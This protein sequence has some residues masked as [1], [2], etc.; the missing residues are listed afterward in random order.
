MFLCNNFWL[1]A[2]C[3]AGSGNTSTSL[4]NHSSQC[5]QAN[6]LP[7]CSMEPMHHQFFYV[8]TIIPLS[9]PPLSHDE[10]QGFVHRPCLHIAKSWPIHMWAGSLAQNPGPYMWIGWNLGPS[11]QDLTSRAGS[12]FTLQ[13][14]SETCPDLF[15]GFRMHRLFHYVPPQWPLSSAHFAQRL[16]SRDKLFLFY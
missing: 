12:M 1:S 14:S 11:K 2:P 9:W 7:M 10:D 8:N 5:W 4:M 16:V 13:V 15:C 3:K 6:D